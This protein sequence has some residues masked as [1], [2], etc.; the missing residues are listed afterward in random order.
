MREIGRRSHL[1]PI[2]HA[3]EAVVIVEAS[4]D[5]LL[6]TVGATGCPAGVN[7]QRESCTVRDA[8]ASECELHIKAAVIAAGHC[9]GKEEQ[10]RQQE[11]A[12]GPCAHARWRRYA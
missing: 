10:G 9:Q 3:E 5:Q 12:F 11:E 2:Q 7:T 1:H 8:F 6:E 4:L